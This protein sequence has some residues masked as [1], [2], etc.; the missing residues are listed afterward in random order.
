MF[1][2]RGVLRLV[3]KIFI[4]IREKPKRDANPPRDTKLGEE[5]HTHI[6]LM[7]LR[8]TIRLV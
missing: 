2:R 8:N 4:T 1:F 5:Q 3:C 6:T 7:N